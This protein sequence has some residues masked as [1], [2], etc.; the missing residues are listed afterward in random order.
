MA[1]TNVND[2]NRQIIEEFRTH[3]GQVGGLFEG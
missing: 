1:E 2:W 3:G